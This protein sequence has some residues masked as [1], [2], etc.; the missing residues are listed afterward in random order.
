MNHYEA[1]TLVMHVISDGHQQITETTQRYG[2]T[3]LF[4][5]IS[6]KQIYC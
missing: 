1:F 6:V 3:K 5:F 2:N 4:I